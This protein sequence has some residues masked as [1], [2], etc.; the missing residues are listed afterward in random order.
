LLIL[1]ARFASNAYCYG[2]VVNCS[3]LKQ[4]PK[5]KVDQGG[6]YDTIPWL[7]RVGESGGRGMRTPTRAPAVS[8]DKIATHAFRDIRFEAYHA[9]RVPAVHYCTRWRIKYRAI[10]YARRAQPIVIWDS[11]V[12]EHREIDGHWMTVEK[13]AKHKRL[14]AATYLKLLVVSRRECAEKRGC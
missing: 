14:S 5:V 7:A 4:F 13:S 12:L 2:I 3:Q 9:D 6:R 8:N 11:R 1:L 10:S